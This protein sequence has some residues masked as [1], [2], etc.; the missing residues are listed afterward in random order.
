[1]S[2]ASNLGFG[3]VRPRK[4]RHQISEL[5]GRP[6]RNRKS[7]N[8]GHPKMHGWQEGFLCVLICLLLFFGVWLFVFLCLCFSLCVFVLMCVLLFLGFWFFGFFCFCCCLGR[9][10]FLCGVVCVCCVC[11]CVC[12]CV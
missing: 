5:V 8:P 9:A 10:C 3:S 7:Q 11:V 6:R 1:M 2:T 12:V 4:W